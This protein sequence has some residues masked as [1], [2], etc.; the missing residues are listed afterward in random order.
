MK[1]VS[2]EILK[3]KMR[4]NPDPLYVRTL[5]RLQDKGTMTIKDFINTGRITTLKNFKERVYPST[6]LP[7]CTDVMLY[8]GDF[9][10]QILKDGEFYLE[11][12]DKH[13]VSIVKSKN[14]ELVELVLWTYYA[15]KK[16]NL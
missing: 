15:S 16:Y 14:I 7:E 6:L 8:I 10:L 3:E 2:E 1:N 13:G 5:Q 12:N 9:Y 4:K 11:M